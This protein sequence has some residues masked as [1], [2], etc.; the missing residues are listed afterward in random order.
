MASHL[1]RFPWARLLLGV[2]VL[3]GLGLASA[4]A[5]LPAYIKK[6]EPQ[7]AWKLKG[8]QD[9]LAG[10][11]LAGT[12]YDLELTSQVWHDITWTHQLQV[13]QPKDVKPDS[14]M[15]IYVTGGKAKADTQLYGM[16][17]ASKI[18]AP[19]AIL[20][21]IPNQPLLGDK[22]ED[23]LIA[24]T[25]VRALADKDDTWPLLFPMAKSVVKAMDALQAFA[26]DEWK[27][28]VKGFVITG[29]SKRGWTT[30]LTGASDPRVVAI[31]PMVIDTLNMQ[32]QM[33]HQLE[34]FGAY[35]DMIH[36]YTERKLVPLPP[37]E[38]AR[39]LWQIVDPYFYRDK[40]T[41]PKMLINGNNDPY[42]STDA[43][44]LYWDDLKGPKYIV[45]VPNAG[46]NLAQ[47]G[48]PE[49]EKRNRAVNAQAAFARSLAN[50]KPLP[51]LS[52]KSDD[53]GD[54]LRIVV[55][56]DPAPKSGR[57]WMATNPTRDFRKAKWTEK[58]VKLAKDQVTGEVMKPKDGC[59]AF[60]VET[61][62][63]IDGIA[64]HLCTQLR[65]VGTPKEQPKASSQE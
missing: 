55:T 34:S 32:A 49:L 53:E 25:F 57:V 47:E 45:Y 40:L 42:W 54:K 56:A 30:W 50:G 51:K 59:V 39:H 22:K 26:K 61:D 41:M 18:Q 63:E 3:L 33:K 60:Y 28:D 37:G 8:K 19:V 2:G 38:E 31:A 15:L 16:T 43:L 6:P 14:T 58:V 20:Y 4:Q 10:T 7:F 48:L 52:W 1:R 27:Q 65:L 13:Y 21:D 12:A 24:E 46:H 11:Q 64:Y 44:N 29:G 5:D 9:I 23:A 35:S 36:D 17:L 62:Y